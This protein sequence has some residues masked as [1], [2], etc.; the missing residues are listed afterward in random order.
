MM[1]LCRMNKSNKSSEFNGSSQL[2]RLGEKGKRVSGLKLF[3]SVFVF[4]VALMISPSVFAAYSS[5]MDPSSGHDSWAVFQIMVGIG[6]GIWYVIKIALLVSGLLGII[7]IVI[8]L[9][10]IRANAL[11]SQSGGSHLKHGIILVILGGL[12]FGAPTLMMMTG[13]SLFGSAPSPVATP[14]DVNCQMV[15]GQYQAGCGLTCPGNQVPGSTGVCQGC[16]DQTYATAQGCM[17]CDG[18]YGVNQY[19]N[20]IPPQVTTGAGSCGAPCPSGESYVSGTCTCNSGLIPTGA[21]NCA[22]PCPSGESYSS[23]ACVCNAGLIPTG[24]GTCAAPC[25]DP[26]AAYV[27]GT[28]QCQS[29]Y[30]SNGAGAC[31]QPCPSGESYSAGVCVCDSPFISNGAGGCAEPCPAGQGYVSGV[32]YCGVTDGVWNGTEYID[33]QDASVCETCDTFTGTELD[34][35]S[36]PI[37]HKYNKPYNLSSMPAP[38]TS[39][40]IVQHAATGVHQILECTCSPSGKVVDYDLGSQAPWTQYSPGNPSSLYF[41]SSADMTTV[42]DRVVALCS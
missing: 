13:Y 42:Q 33:S 5:S 34:N 30:V 39:C 1:Q 37:C 24:A 6:T 38:L 8:G 17:S 29:P 25:S 40:G 26:H 41:L 7:F 23:G 20:C 32:C 21:G 12:L 35:A 18:M 3:L 2:N 27:N 16:P 9:L 15:Y 4:F 19:C 28:C 11:D 31:A 10:K 22:A 36:A 14:E